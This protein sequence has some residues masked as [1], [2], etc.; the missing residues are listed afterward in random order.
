MGSLA[1]IR[2]AEMGYAV[3][4]FDRGAQPLVAGSSR[5]PAHLYS[6]AMYF[7]LGAETV[8]QCF[9]DAL[10]F[11]RTIPEGVVPRPTVC[12]IAHDDPR[13]TDDLEAACLANKE[14]YARAVQL[15]PANEVFGT[16]GSYYQA[17]THRQLEAFAA[18]PLAEGE[19]TP[20][21]NDGWMRL[22][23]HKIAW[24]ELKDPVF[25]LHEYGLN[26]RRTGAAIRDTLDRLEKHAQLTCVYGTNLE[27]VR[28]AGAAL[29]L[30]WVT[31]DPVEHALQTVRT[32]VPPWRSPAW[33][34]HLL[35]L[36]LS[37]RRMRWQLR[38]WAR[39]AQ[40]PTTL[41]PHAG[42]FDYLVNCAGQDVG[43]WDDTL[44]AKPRLHCTDVKVAGLYTFTRPIGWLPDV[45]LLGPRGMH[46]ISPAN[47][48]TVTA[49]SAR[50]LATYLFNGKHLSGAGTSSTRAAIAASPAATRA[51]HGDTGENLANIGSDVTARAPFLGGASEAV[52]VPGS[53]ETVTGTSDAATP[54][55]AQR[56]HATGAYQQTR[57]SAS[58]SS[59]KGGSAPAVAQRFAHRFRGLFPLG[60]L[61]PRLGRVAVAP[62]SEKDLAYLSVQH[63]KEAGLPAASALP[64]F[65][66]ADALTGREALRAGVH[67]VQDESAPPSR[68]TSKGL[69]RALTTWCTDTSP[70]TSRP[71]PPS[72]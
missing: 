51:L 59:P 65:A 60:P 35:S 1:A 5:I 38:Q 61:S 56:T 70:D 55:G 47:R 24:S 57:N 42:R 23:A 58:L 40:L 48:F 6:G 27:E 19:P 29:D 63:A 62:H 31:H 45:Y 22:F 26:M 14:R 72:P 25:L 13:S 28:R 64:Y 12:G 3:T 49:T 37:P 54:P 32:E 4:L 53:V 2:L 20:S 36:D 16:P 66:A 68:E 69:E 34:K 17:Y 7:D 18:E 15:D 71:A 21:D 67:D 52:A 39:Y 43:H 10:I 50:W 33:R 41:S 46:Q 30:T 11:A 8:A 9:D 44:G